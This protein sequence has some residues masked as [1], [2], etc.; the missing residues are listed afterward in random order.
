MDGR[1]YTAVDEEMPPAFYQILLRLLAEEL[2]GSALTVQTALGRHLLLRC[3]QQHIPLYTHPAGVRSGNPIFR[4]HPE[5]GIA[6]MQEIL[7][8]IHI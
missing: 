2:P 5:F 4:F 1:L 3:H 8:L 7:S 6:G